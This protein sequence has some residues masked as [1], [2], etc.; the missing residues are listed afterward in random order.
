M[1]LRTALTATAR[2]HR[3]ARQECRPDVLTWNVS[4]RVPLGKPSVSESEHAL[5]SSA[6]SPPSILRATGSSLP[7]SL[8]PEE[9]GP[10]ELSDQ[11]WEIRTG[12]A[13][14]ILQ[15]TLPTFFSTGL[16][17]SVDTSGGNE[18]GDKSDEI[19]IYSPNVRLEYRPPVPFPPP[20]PRTL[21]VEG[22]PLYMG[23]SVF[24]RHTLSAL[25]T[26]LRVELQRVRVHGPR[27]SS[28]PPLDSSANP[29]A[30][31][32]I[33]RSQQSKT[34]SNREKSLF[35]GLM[36]HGINRVS[37]AEGG[38]QVNSTYTFSPIT[39]LIH[40]HVIDSIHPAPHQAFFSAL[41][42]ALS[43]IGLGSTR[44]AGESGM[45]RAQPLSQPQPSRSEI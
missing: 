26:D 18:K 43:K 14:Y 29:N 4:S 11:E 32:D 19:S 7:G 27:S 44:D 5:P 36:V 34:R 16:I 12:R 22:L 45:A 2:L 21:H 15:Q 9:E 6:S 10:G 30:P 39:G 35:V 17:S 38:W 28:G 3:M 24:V 37:K 31:G 40:L 23:S 42:A 20:F 33:H 41:Q 1:S 8:P 13:I 25:Y